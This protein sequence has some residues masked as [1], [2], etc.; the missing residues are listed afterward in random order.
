M[1]ITALLHRLKGVKQTGNAWQACCPAHDDHR[2]S[3]SLIEGKRG[4][5]LHC[6]AGC[7]VDAICRA[8]NLTVADLFD[9]EV[10]DRTNRKMNIVA[11]YDYTD[12]AGELLFQ[13]CRMEPKDFR[14]RRPDPT[15][16][17]GWTWNTK[18]VRRVLFRLPNV[19]AAVKGGRRVILCE[20]E[21]D[22]LA[23]ERAGFAATC[24]PGGAG[25]W[26]QDYGEFLRRAEVV[27]IADKDEPG[28]RH[29]ADVAA[30]LKGIAGSVKVI[31]LPDVEGKAVKDAADYF[32][33]GGGAADLDEQARGS[34]EWEANVITNQSPVHE[35]AKVE[36][37]TRPDEN[38]ADE[39]SRKSVA[40]R[41]VELVEGM[42]LFHDS[43][44]RSFVRVRVNSH[45]EIWAVNSMQFRNLLAKMFWKKMR[46]AI[47]RNALADAVAILAGMACHDNPEEPVFLRVA[48]YHEAILIDLCDPEWRV[49]EVTSN[50]WM[51][52]DESP[53]AFIRT[54]AMRPLPM[55]VPAEQGSL[56]HLWELLNVTPSQRPLLAGALLNYFHPQGPYF[57]TNFI[58]EQGS[59]KSCAA[60]ILRTLVDPNEIP[61]RSPPRE[62]RD[63]LIQAANNWCVALDNLSGLPPWLS[64][65]LCRLATGGGHSARQLFTDG[66]EFS[67]SVKRPVILN[68]IDDAATRPDLAERALQIELE[69]IPDGHRIPEKQLWQG[70]EDA[71]P[72]IFSALLNGLAFALRDL[73][74]VRL[75][76][77]PRMADPVLWATAGETAFGWPQ[78]TFLS[79][80][81]ENL[82]EGAIASV[83]AHPVG[84]A[85]R[86]LLD[87]KAE[88]LGEAQRL[89]E[90]LR[91]T[92][93]EEL[94][95][96]RNWPA[97]ARSLSVSLRRLAPALR[98]SGVAVEFAKERRRQ[99]R[100]CKVG[101]F[102]S[103]ASPEPPGEANDANDAKT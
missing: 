52:L 33:N 77:L 95:K 98:R 23:M 99:I 39:E 81:L 30:R 58:G 53:V 2:P 100:L 4:I 24:N 1:T 88:W 90:A 8:L 19:I 12:E 65:G 78:G 92:A 75:S 35:N 72:V 49:V 84:L 86:Q 18:D 10:P 26:R 31:E 3:L 94:T 101:N 67:L 37:E 5:V 27:I 71:R 46:K 80:Y 45:T 38:E 40:T 34:S 41:L 17:H 57:V 70:F 83:E 20:G 64:D 55:P 29:A 82:K 13:V 96:A 60:K 73:A 93:S 6:H 74:N 32:A 9:G 87:G 91:E 21:R 97:N 22:V 56:D 11:A 89:L 76:A 36:S 14:Q 85:I 68:G 7:T 25:K 103:P 50:G 79:V 63:L 61:L 66:E 62:E 28:R 43:Q 59:A 69:P 42:P 16:K 102:A 54:G 47:N 44:N 51:V 48:P 15:A